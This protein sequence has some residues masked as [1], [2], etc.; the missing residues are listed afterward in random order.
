MFTN[1]KKASLNCSSIWRLFN[2]LAEG[3]FSFIQDNL[4][5]WAMFVKLALN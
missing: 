3:I 1:G 5:S 4:Y 2:E